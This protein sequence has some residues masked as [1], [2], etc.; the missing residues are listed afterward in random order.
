VLN[1]GHN[2]L[3]NGIVFDQRTRRFETFLVEQDSHVRRIAELVVVGRKEVAA[4]TGQSFGHPGTCTVGA[5]LDMDCTV[6]WG[7]HIVAYQHHHMKGLGQH[8]DMEQ[9]TVVLL[10]DNS[11]CSIHCH[12]LHSL[13][14]DLDLYPDLDHVRENRFDSFD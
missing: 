8:D 9:G 12:V 7:S 2:T 1:V 10:V 4:H 5:G 3:D 11:D 6:D 14:H 13:D